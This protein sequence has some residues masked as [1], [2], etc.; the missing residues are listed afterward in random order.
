M[1]ELKEN[2]TQLDEIDDEILQLFLRRM[3][4]AE[5]IGR[6]KKERN[7]PV[8]DPRREKEK[9]ETIKEKTPEELREY[10]TKLFSLIM[11]LSRTRQNHILLQK[12][13]EAKPILI[14]ENPG[15]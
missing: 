3:K 5:E 11:E 2:R 13:A 1:K 6:W 15:R 8:L 12:D 9:L 4:I 10:S 7:L 14:L